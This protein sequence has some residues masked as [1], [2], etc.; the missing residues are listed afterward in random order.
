MQCT[1]DLDLYLSSTLII[2]GLL[3][4]FRQLTEPAPYGKHV[5]KKT[6]TKF[7]L[8]SAKYGWFIQESP[9][10]FV[11]V[12]IVLYNQQWDTLG[13]KML[14]VM[15][16]GHYFH[17]SFI[18]SVI[19]KG[20][21]TPLYIVILAV[22]FC[23][24]NGFLQGHCMVYGATYPENWYKDIRFLSGVMIFFIGMAINIHSD[25]ILRNL[26]KP[27]DFGYKIPEGGMFKYVSG[28]NYFGEIVEWF[29]YALAT[30]SLPGFA[31]SLFTLCSIG[32]RAY[33]HHKFYLLEFKHYPR[34]RKAVIP[35]IF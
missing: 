10:F 17:R 29:G 9:S 21:P 18:Y 23:S 4:L 28:A 2:S 26:R 13:C 30:W 31:F 32:P 33:H 3:F 14:L 8:I 27:S 7:T 12:L 11:P 19:T 1:Q 35:F 24:Y 16:C 25:Y 20:R 34:E 6:K 22:I 5:P 15:F